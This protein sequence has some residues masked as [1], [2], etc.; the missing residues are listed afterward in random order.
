MS[1]NRHISRLEAMLEDCGDTWDLSTNDKAAIQYAVDRIAEL[2]GFDLQ[3]SAL[4][5]ELTGVRNTL[6]AVGRE[7]DELARDAERWRECERHARHGGRSW[8]LTTRL[9]G[10]TFA[11]AIDAA[12]AKRKETT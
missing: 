8:Y 10:N 12:I 11:A 2:E 9:D 6:E 5:H 1:D 3:N 7:K 4:R